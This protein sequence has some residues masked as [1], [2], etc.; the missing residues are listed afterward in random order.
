MDSFNVEPK[1]LLSIVV[2]YK[3]IYKLTAIEIVKTFG[4]KVNWSAKRFVFKSVKI[5]KIV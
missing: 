5:V 3:L 1:T 2:S 4:L